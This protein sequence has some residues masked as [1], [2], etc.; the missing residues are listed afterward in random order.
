MTELAVMR[1]FV[2]FYAAICSAVMGFAASLSFASSVVAFAAARF[3]SSQGLDVRD[4]GHGRL[5]ILLIALHK[6]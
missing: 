2:L 5:F 1:T 4:D 6:Y 3:V